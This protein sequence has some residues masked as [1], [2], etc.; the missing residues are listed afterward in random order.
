MNNYDPE[1]YSITIKK[2]NI[3]G[4][5]YFVARIAEIPNVEDYGES[6]SEAYELI[7]D[8]IRTSMHAYAEKG[9]A[10]PRPFITEERQYS[11]RV[12]LR[13]PHYL[14][15]ELDLAASADGASLNSYMTSILSRHREVTSP[16]F[17]F[18]MSIV[19]KVKKFTFSNITDGFMD[20]LRPPTEANNQL[21]FST[22]NKPITFTRD[23]GLDN[24][25]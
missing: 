7:L 16:E 9:M 24:Y 21:S 12:T 13:L 11:G 25:V 14:H 6:Y 20:S 22:T 1:N 18:M 5:N 8:T 2:E 4:E 15:R 23:E 17:S 19:G 3:E 10:F